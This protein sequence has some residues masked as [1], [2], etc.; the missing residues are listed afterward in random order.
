MSRRRAPAAT[1]SVG[2]VIVGNVVFFIG[3]VHSLGA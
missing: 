3:V 2:Y 1:S